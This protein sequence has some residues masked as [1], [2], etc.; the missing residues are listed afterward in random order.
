LTGLGTF[1]RDKVMSGKYF[2]PVF[3]TWPELAALYDGND[4]AK[5]IVE[6]RPKEMFRKGYDIRFVGAK[7]IG[8]SQDAL[9]ETAKDVLKYGANLLLNDRV[10]EGLIF[11][12]LFGGGV[13]IIGA[14]DGQDV[15]TPLNED[16]IRSIKYLNWIDR[17]FLAARSWYGDPFSPKGQ[18]VET[19]Q[20][21]SIF[22]TSPQSIVHESR[23]IRFDGARVEILL[24]RQLAGWTLS[25]LQAPY[26]ALRMFDTSFQALANLMTDM[27][28]A[29]FS[30]KGLA[31]MIT[32]GNATT[33]QSRMQMVDMMRSAARMMLVDA[34]YEKFERTA[35]PMTGVSDAIQNFMTRLASAA[36][37]PETI[38]F[39]RSPAGMNATGEADFQSF[40]D[41]VASDQKTILEPKL[42]RLYT[43]ICK[44]KDS[45]TK[46]VVPEGG[47]EFLWHELQ[48]LTKTQQSLVNFTQAQADNLNIQNGTLLPEEVALSRF[49][50]A[51]NSLETQ[52]DVASR[53]KSLKAELQYGVDEA[54]Q[55]AQLGPPI[56]SQGEPGGP[57][58]PAPGPA[59]P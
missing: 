18:T 3:L 41:S 20:V 27:S 32:S 8:P 50:G 24:Q 44:A 19:Y 52:I 25:V 57:Q 29:V 45:P 40:Y 7:G 33:V 5:K 1:G 59:R 30:M 6:K 14:D 26:D 42:N 12:R 55:R 43:L 21:T 11:G 17:R 47:I 51:S 37:M 22:G 36:E 35:T 39:G 49:S 53:K 10:L 46:G 4:I 9:A 15:S 58:L 28:Q 13:I 48:Q 16:N 38:L 2:Q 54:T 31:D 23:V 34:D 56:P